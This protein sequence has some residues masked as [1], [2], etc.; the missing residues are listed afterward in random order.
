MW[1]TASKSETVT[2][3]GVFSMWDTA[4]AGG[5][6]LPPSSR[7]M[8]FGHV[9]IRGSP[10]VPS[11]SSVSELNRSYFP[12]FSLIPLPADTALTVMGAILFSLLE[13]P[14]H[15]AQHLGGS[16]HCGLLLA[17]LLC[18]ANV[19]CLDVGISGNMVDVREDAFCQKPNASV[20]PRSWLCV[21]GV[22]HWQI[23]LQMERLRHTRRGPL[24][25]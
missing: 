16:G 21:R 15:D 17:P 5:I 6:G 10:S 4:F 3:L 23:L 19:A 22:P 8:I 12:R 18:D 13:H 1:S 7:R 14:V 2:I 25:C 11:S 20:C 24:D 9:S